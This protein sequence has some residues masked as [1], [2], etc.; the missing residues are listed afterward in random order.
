[1]VKEAKGNYQGDKPPHREG[2][3][4]VK[5]AAGREAKEEAGGKAEIRYIVRIAGKDL[6]GSIPVYRAICAIKGIN[7]RTAKMVAAIFER[8]AGIAFDCK[9]G[10]IDEGK[11]KALEEI[12]LNPAKYGIPSWAMNRQ[13]DRE[14]GGN[15]HLVGGELEF[16]IRKDLQRLAAIKSYRGLRHSWGLTVR[17]QRTRSTHRGKG[18]VVGVIKKDMKKAIAPAKKEEKEKGGKK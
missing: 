4:A 7:H 2:E 14:S 1:M 9:L 3:M 5:E 15:M 8:N 18:G 17:G 13:H 16:S 10:E 11:A 12:I 6:D